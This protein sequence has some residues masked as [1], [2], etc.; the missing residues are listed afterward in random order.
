MPVSEVPVPNGELFGLDFRRIVREDIPGWAALIKRIAAAEKPTWFEK[1]ADLEHALDSKKNDLSVDSVIGVDTSGMP[2]V[3]A[4]VALN[5]ESTTVYG[6]GGVDPEYQGRGIGR[7][8]LEWQRA[9]AAERINVRGRTSSDSGTPE[10]QSPRLRLY[11]ETANTAEQRLFSRAGWKVVRYFNEMN[12]PISTRNDA[13]E[14]SAAIPRL[15]LAEGY[16]IRPW[17][18][19]Y[20]HEMRHVH[21]AAFADHWGSEERDEQSWKFTV[22]HPLN[23]RDLSAVVV[24]KSNGKVVGYQL[25][26]YDPDVLEDFGREEGYTELLGVV[27]DH[28]GRGL[29]KALLVDAMQRFA[30]AGMTTA[31]LDVDSENPSGALAIYTSMGY[32][33]VKQSMAWDLEL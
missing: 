21:N 24:E 9:R 20:D 12:R 1:E 5:P 11:S 33:P 14:N 8:V 15:V 28:R 32:S 23:R 18:A 29:A 22:E 16:E 26:S 13:E 10:N 19:E 4:R 27:R 7:G 31:A 25:A 6:M 3:F 17:T 2:R 30:A